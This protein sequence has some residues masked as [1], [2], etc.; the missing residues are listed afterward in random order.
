MSNAIRTSPVLSGGSDDAHT[1]FAIN[2]SG[3]FSHRL[4]HTP[5]HRITRLSIGWLIAIQ[6]W[7]MRD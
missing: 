7:N 6:W 3:F 5:F 2:Q 1:I 4:L